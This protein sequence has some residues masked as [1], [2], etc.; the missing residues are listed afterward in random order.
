MRENRTR[1][2]LNGMAKCRKEPEYWPGH[3][4]WNQSKHISMLSVLGNMYNYNDYPDK[5]GDIGGI[6]IILAPTRYCH[7][8]GK[9]WGM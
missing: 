4:F 2:Y 7:W 6:M 1:I 5:I 3:V 9:A 8:K